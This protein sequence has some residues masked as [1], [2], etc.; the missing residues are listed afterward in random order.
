[1]ALKEEL[2]LDGSIETLEHECLLN[3]VYTGTMI[4]RV[5]YQYFRKSG[6]TDVQF[7]VL[8]QLK[9]AKDGG[10]S[11]VE[12]SKRL[13]VNKADMTGIIDRL[14]KAGLVERKPHEHDRRVNVV[15]LTTKGLQVNDKLEPGYYKEVEKVMAGLQR[16]EVQGLI[17]ALEVIR[18]NLRKVE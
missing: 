4:N 6:I 8:M 9:Y 1:M 16:D 11:Q 18:K 13:V 12:L 10:L 7:N 17:R 14:E 15:R 3:I 2:G 5:A